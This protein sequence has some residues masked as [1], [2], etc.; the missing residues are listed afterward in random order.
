[1]GY[2]GRFILGYGILPTPLTKPHTCKTAL[3]CIYTHYII[4]VVLNINLGLNDKHDKRDNK[5]IV[6][7][8]FFF[9][10]FFTFKCG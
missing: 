1:M 5:A 4:L 8:G 9:V 6:V 7:V 3:S 10:F 2:F